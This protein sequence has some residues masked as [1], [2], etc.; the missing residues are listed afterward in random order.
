MIEGI[1]EENKGGI[2]YLL[3]I[4]H[5]SRGNPPSQIESICLLRYISL[6]LKKIGARFVMTLMYKIISLSINIR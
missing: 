2:D 6:H 5:H 3:E 4:N 1:M